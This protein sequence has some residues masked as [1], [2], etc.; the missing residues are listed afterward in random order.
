[1]NIHF[2]NMSES[3]IYIC[4]EEHRGIKLHRFQYMKLCSGTVSQ[5]ETK[6]SLLAF[7]DFLVLIGKNRQHQRPGT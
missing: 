7:D 4:A 5:N 3:E 6:D 1:M 2:L